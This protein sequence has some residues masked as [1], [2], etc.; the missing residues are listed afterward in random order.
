VKQQKFQAVKE[1]KLNYMLSRPC[2]LKLK[3]QK[4]GSE[5]KAINQLPVKQQKFQAVC[6]QKFLGQGVSFTA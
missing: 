4:F 3:V 5:I 1:Q 6:V 2:Q